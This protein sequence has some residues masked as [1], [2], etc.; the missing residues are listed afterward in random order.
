MKLNAYCLL[1]VLG[2]GSVGYSQEDIDR[3]GNVVIDPYIGIP[4][5]GSALLNGTDIMNE[6]QFSVTEN[7]SLPI[8]FGGKFEFMLNNRIG[9][10]FDCN[11][12]KYGYKTTYETYDYVSGTYKDTSLGWEQQKTRFMVR[13]QFH[14]VQ[15]ER[16]DLYMGAGLGATLVKTQNKENELDEID[17]DLFAPIVFFDRV[18]DPLAAR[19]FF[20]TRVLFIENF[21]MLMELGLG[22][23]ALI[24]IGLSARF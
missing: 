11:Y 18:T 10:G 4:N 16:V 22:S 20:G 15:N 24:N 21:G 5:A 3:S 19:I 1:L 17:Y 12:E 23:G 2:I 9:L 6:D 14:P 7:T 8:S 13:F